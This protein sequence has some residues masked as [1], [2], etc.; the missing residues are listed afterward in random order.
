M[1][2]SEVNI[3]NTCDWPGVSA[4]AEAAKASAKPRQTKAPCYRFFLRWTLIISCPITCSTFAR[5]SWVVH[6][7]QKEVHLSLLPSPVVFSNLK[8]CTATVRYRNISW[9]ATRRRP[10]S[11]THLRECFLACTQGFADVQQECVFV[12]S[13][14]SV[15]FLSW[16]IGVVGLCQKNGFNT[17]WLSMTVISS[18][19]AKAFFDNLRPS[20]FF[21]QFKKRLTSTQLFSYVYRKIQLPWDIAQGHV[22]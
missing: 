13:P 20:S 2:I 9:K 21:D 7:A 4:G 10:C 17:N 1:A 19:Q 5:A 3:C 14:S 11:P 15:D 18:L 8:R 6:N 22:T 16:G 12:A